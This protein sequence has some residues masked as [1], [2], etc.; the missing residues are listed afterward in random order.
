MQ[1][2]L[3]L[4]SCFG[5]TVFAMRLSGQ[6]AVTAAFE[7]HAAHG[8]FLV[9][10]FQSGLFCFLCSQ[11]TAPFPARLRLRGSSL[12]SATERLIANQ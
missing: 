2:T 7:P 4:G 11:S 3:L 6:I 1:N 12:L 8:H 5:G 10:L 9:P